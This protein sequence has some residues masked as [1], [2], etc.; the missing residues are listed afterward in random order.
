MAGLSP[1]C[2]TLPGGGNHLNFV[3]IAV[4]GFVA[5]PWGPLPARASGFCLCQPSDR[6]TVMKVINHSVP[7][8]PFLEC[9]LR[10]RLAALVMAR[11]KH[12]MRRTTSSIQTAGYCQNYYS[13]LLRKRSGGG[14]PRG[15]K[16]AE[17][18]LLGPHLWPLEFLQIALFSPHRPPCAQ[19]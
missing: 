18:R 2:P 9:N 6:G 15:V 17:R 11:C 4:P 5:A 16:P 12:R 7:R 13:L 14:E 1:V 19:N 10:H 8:F 3:E